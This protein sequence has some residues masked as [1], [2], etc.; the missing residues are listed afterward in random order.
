[1]ADKYEHAAFPFR[2]VL[3]YYR[4]SK[5][6]HFHKLKVWVIL[7]SLYWASWFLS[8][9]DLCCCWSL[10]W[11]VCVCVCALLAGG[12]IHTL[13]HAVTL[14]STRSWIDFHADVASFPLPVERL[15]GEC[16]AASLCNWQAQLAVTVSVNFIKQRL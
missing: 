12:C 5:M 9:S 7:F 2:C 10:L 8:E 1:M 13:T 16:L 3:T 6:I 15:H 11:W 4:L 14:R